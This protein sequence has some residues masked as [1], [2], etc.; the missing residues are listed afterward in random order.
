MEA[1]GSPGSGV[2]GEEPAGG[3]VAGKAIG[4]EAGVNEVRGEG[5]GSKRRRWGKR[6]GQE[7][8]SQQHQENRL[9]VNMNVSCR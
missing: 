3:V 5:G 1:E 9:V 8:I 6:S 4:S 2:H 7:W